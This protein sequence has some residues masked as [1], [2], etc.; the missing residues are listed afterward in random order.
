MTKIKIASVGSVVNPCPATPGYIRFQADFRPNNMPL[1]ME[2]MV[3]G[4]RSISQIIQ[5][6]RS[7]FSKNINIFHHLKLELC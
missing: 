7:L 2:N 6:K 1:K 5:F 4:R 3:C